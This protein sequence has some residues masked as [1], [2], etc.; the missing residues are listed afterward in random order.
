MNTLEKLQAIIDHCKCEVIVS[1]R[2]NTTCYQSIEDFFKTVCPDPGDQDKRIIRE[3]LAAGIIYSI[4]A[5][6]QTPIGSH[7][8]YGPSLE[9]VVDRM[10]GWLP[11]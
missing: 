4:Q 6:P 2:E 1:A 3:C 9:S 8:A 10:F 11:L 5:Y 7:I